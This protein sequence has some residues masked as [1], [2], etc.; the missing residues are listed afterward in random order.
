MSY[1]TYT[2]YRLYYFWP[3]HPDFITV[4]LIYKSTCISLKSFFIQIDDEYH[5]VCVEVYYSLIDFHI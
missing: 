3:W 1:D 4:R 2:Y 5:Q